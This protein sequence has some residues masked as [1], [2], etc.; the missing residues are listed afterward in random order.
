MPRE[1]DSGSAHCRCQPGRR[2]RQRIEPLRTTREEFTN[3]SDYSFDT[4]NRSLQVP[5]GEG[6][7]AIAADAQLPHRAHIWEAPQR[8]ASC[9][10]GAEAVPVWWQPDGAGAAG[11]SNQLHKHLCAFEGWPSA[12]CPLDVK[13]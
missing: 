8:K 7:A 10:A 6:A 1:C 9:A 3:R 12:G 4:E 13:I 5:A 2:L 11:G